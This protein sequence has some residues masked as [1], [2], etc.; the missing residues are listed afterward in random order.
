[1]SGSFLSIASAI[2]HELVESSKFFL[3]TS[4]R[5]FCWE[6]N[7]SPSSWRWTSPRTLFRGFLGRCLC[8]CTWSHRLT[9]WMS[10][11]T[12]RAAQP[13]TRLP[14]KKWSW[15]RGLNKERR[16]DSRIERWMR[17]KNNTGCRS[18]MARWSGWRERSRG[19][20]L[21]KL[22]D[23]IHTGTQL[24]LTGSF[25]SL[26]E[27]GV[28]RSLVLLSKQSIHLLQ[29]Q[30]SSSNLAVVLQQATTSLGDMQY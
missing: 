29:K 30:K 26:S 27:Y 2:H 13:K 22:A 4:S 9:F 8:R 14:W 15:T 20:F 5:G 12:R 19:A 17:C 23:L 6:V 1:M 7:V 10:G 25:R 24:D 21:L 18:K 28:P 3:S 16:K 11:W